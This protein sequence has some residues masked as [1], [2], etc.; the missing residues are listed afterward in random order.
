MKN[1][2]RYYKKLNIFCNIYVILKVVYSVPLSFSYAFN[3]CYSLILLILIPLRHINGSMFVLLHCYYKNKIPKV[4]N[5]NVIFWYLELIINIPMFWY[6]NFKMFIYI[7]LYSTTKLILKHI[8]SCQ[9]Y[10]HVNILCKINFSNIL[11]KT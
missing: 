1:Y 5:S 11:W 9:F 2:I 3:K 10:V 4:S 7:C 6:K 8:F